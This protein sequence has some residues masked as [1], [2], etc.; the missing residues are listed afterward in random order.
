MASTEDV[1][2]HSRSTPRPTNGNHNSNS[3]SNSNS[4]G[5]DEPLL[6]RAGD[7][8]QQEGKGLP[9]NFVLGIEPVSTNVHERL[10]ILTHD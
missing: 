7:A 1:P 5:E 6:G 4:R 2:A 10:N 9:F 8:A 3:N